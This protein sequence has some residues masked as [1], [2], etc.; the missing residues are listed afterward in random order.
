MQNACFV[1]VGQPQQINTEKN[2]VATHLRLPKCQKLCDDTDGCESIHYDTVTT[3]CT[4]LRKRTVPLEDNLALEWQ[5]PTLRAQGK[6][7]SDYKWKPS[8]VRCFRPGR[9]CVGSIC[10]GALGKATDKCTAHGKNPDE[11][12]AVRSQRRLVAGAPA[13][14]PR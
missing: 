10:S 8:N 7:H 3:V 5:G 9:Q 1:Q 12:A 13:G 6:L 4:L 14:N 11:P 2:K